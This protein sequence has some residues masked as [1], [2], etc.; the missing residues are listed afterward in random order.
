M[1]S[2]RWV[3][4]ASGPSLITPDLLAL[5]GQAKLCV[6]NNAHR[7]APW[8][9][10][11]YAGDHQW[12]AKYHGETLG[13]GGRVLTCRHADTRLPKDDRIE[14]TP[15]RTGWWLTGELPFCTGRNSGHAAICLVHALFGATDIA[16]LGFDF[17]NTGGMAHFFGSHDG[18]VNPVNWVGWNRDMTRLAEQA[19]D[20]GVRI[21]N[22]SRETSITRLPRMTI[23][24]WLAC[25]AD[26]PPAAALSAARV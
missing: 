17:Q 13:F 8:A 10:L 15:H 20:I 11:L 21:T 16:L 7:L 18:L 22:C 14:R 23:G 3:I 6:V 26:D 19:A 25:A 4:A 12:W 2:D 9:D 5:R 1:G 24:D